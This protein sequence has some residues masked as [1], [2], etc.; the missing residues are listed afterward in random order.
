MARVSETRLH[1]GERIQKRKQRSSDG[2]NLTRKEEKGE[3]G[4]RQRREGKR[5]RDETRGESEE[6]EKEKRKSTK[7]HQTSMCLTRRT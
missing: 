4:E 6:K 1:E 7:R 2:R 3:R 5:G